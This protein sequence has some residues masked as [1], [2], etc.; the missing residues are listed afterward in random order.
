M[1]AAMQTA[2]ASEGQFPRLCVCGNKISGKDTHQVCSACLGLK[3]AQ[4]AIDAPGSCEHCARF[5]LKSLR[6]T[7]ACQASL[8]GEDPLMSTSPASAVTPQVSIPVE[9]PSKATLSWGEQLDACTPLPNVPSTDDEEEDLFDFEDE[10]QSEFLLS[11]EEDYEDSFFLPPSQSAQPLAAAGST[12]GAGEAPSSPL[13][14]VDLQDVCKCAAEKLNIPWPT[15]VAETAKSQLLEEVAVTWKDKPFTGKVT[16][17]GGSVLD[18][19]G[20]EKEGL[21]R[22][23]L[24]AAHLHPKRSAATN[25][26][27]PSKAD[28]FQSNMTDRAYKAV[29]LSVRALNAIS[30]LTAYQAELQ[31]EVS[32][33]PGQ[34][35][36]DEICVVMDLSLR[37]QRCAVQAAGK[38]MATMVI[39][40]WG[41]W[42][43]L[44]NLSNRE[45]ETIVDAPVVSEGVFGSALTQMQKRCEEKKR[46]DEALQLCLP[47][48]PQ[49]SPPLPPRLTYAQ[50]TGHPRPSFRIPRRPRP[51]PKVDNL[52]DLIFDKHFDKVFMDLTPYVDEALKI[53]IP[54]DLTVQNS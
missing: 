20:I 35:Q 18:L 25:V 49:S 24:V 11:D 42:L 23:P 52:L 8:S 38:A 13:L 4:A 26:T 43:N 9:L 21:L 41:R 54:E 28:R 22:M 29:A 3:H 1:A 45:K 10:G 51:P 27:L 2:L 34:A 37:L 6:Q 30:L 15:V 33:T 19:E 46:D 12:E 7:L 16:I 48:K 5:T 32:A 31:D 47:R 14:G 44:A 36:W 40:E 50:A 53:S 17:Q 39:Q